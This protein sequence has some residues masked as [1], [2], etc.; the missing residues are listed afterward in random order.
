VD[1]RKEKVKGEVSPWKSIGKPKKGT[2]EN[3]PEAKE[4]KKQLPFAPLVCPLSKVECNT[5]GQKKGKSIEKGVELGVYV[6]RYVERV[7]GRKE[8]GTQEGLTRIV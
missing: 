7:E 4:R 3:N 8:E 5:K 1:Y 6:L 2:Q